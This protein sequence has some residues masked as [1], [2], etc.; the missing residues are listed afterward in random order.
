M[1]YSF[2]FCGTD[3][4]ELGLRY[5]PENADTYVHDSLSFDLSEQSYEARDGGHFFGTS[6]KPKS[7]VL[8]CYYEN[9]YAL[10]GLTSRINAVFRRGRSGKLVFTDRPWLYYTATVTGIDISRMLNLRNGFVTIQMKAYY[11]LAITD[12]ALVQDNEYRNDML[13][14]SAMFED[15][16]M[17]PTSFTDMTAATTNP[18][19]LFNGGTER[20]AV[21]IG[22]AG[23]V[24]TGV[25][26]YNRTTKQECDFVGLNEGSAAHYVVCDGKTGNTYWSDTGNNAFI[27]HDRGFIELEPSYPIN[28]ELQVSVSATGTSVTAVYGSF[29][30][31]MLGK[32][33]YLDNNFRRIVNVV[34]D[35]E[36]TVNANVTQQ[37]CVNAPVYTM[38]EIVVTPYST[39][40]LALLR[41]D[42]K[43]TFA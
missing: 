12:Y 11:P 13:F 37:D 3:V 9:T 40:N 22:I 18:I 30:E 41:F 32:Y 34:S 38:N 42:Y 20:A 1:L 2:S 17:P 6:L 23:N 33:I 24:G 36:L 8:R 25:S 7:F 43:H 19:L 29:N 31:E 39:M 15:D 28:R 14:N 26:I 21:R 10:D 5:A 16:I 4:T 27:Y 35:T